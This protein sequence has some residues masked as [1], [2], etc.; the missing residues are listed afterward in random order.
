MQRGTPIFRTGH[1]QGYSASVA[2]GTQEM[3]Y[4][5]AGDKDR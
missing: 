3:R 5:V 1:V 2:G 4:Y